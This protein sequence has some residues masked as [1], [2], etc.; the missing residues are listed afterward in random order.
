MM[1]I[2]DEQLERSAVVA[3]CRMNRERN[4]DGSNGYEKELGFSP[5]EFLKERIKH[6]QK[7]AWL[8]LCC[9]TG[10]ALIQASQRLDSEEL[11]ERLAIV[12]I[13][14][15]GMF[16][17]MP[18]DP[19]SLTLEV[20]SIRTWRPSREFDLITCVHGFHYVGDKL[21]MIAKARS[22]LADDGLFVASFDLQALRLGHGGISSRRFAS[23]LRKAGYVLDRRRHL[24]TARGK[25]MTTFPYEYLGADDQAGPNYTGQPA[26][27]SHYL[28]IE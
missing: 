19:T 7:P 6:R 12:G 27:N 1:L 11:S 8:D 2:D 22:C 24:I 20:G 9:G 26:V 10:R 25:S 18:K 17:A 14:L 28:L 21:G 15:V 3:N 5:L 23:S 16:D 13:D 4:L